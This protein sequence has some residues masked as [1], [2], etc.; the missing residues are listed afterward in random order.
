MLPR[1]ALHAISTDREAPGMVRFCVGC[2]SF[3]LL[4]LRITALLILCIFDA[5]RRL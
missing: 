5:L 1:P 4:G 3:A 2:A